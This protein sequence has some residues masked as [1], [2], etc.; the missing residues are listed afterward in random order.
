MVI[1]VND[2]EFYDFLDCDKYISNTCNGTVTQYIHVFF[3]GKFN[4]D[5]ELQDILVL[6][7]FLVAARVAT[8]FALKRFNFSDN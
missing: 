6:A 3:G 2:S 5:N 7:L 4:K 8:F 1:A